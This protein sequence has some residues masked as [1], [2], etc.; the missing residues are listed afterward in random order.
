M[1]STSPDPILVDLG[2]NFMR[3]V[4]VNRDGQLAK[5]TMTPTEVTIAEGTPGERL[6]DY[7]MVQRAAAM[8]QCV[9]DVTSS[10]DLD[11]ASRKGALRVLV[12]AIEMV[13]S[14]VSDDLAAEFARVVRVPSNQVPSQTDLRIANAQ[15]TQWV[16]SLV[17]MASVV[18]QGGKY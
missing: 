10:T 15:F 18:I 1:G 8:I 13:Q 16:G 9:S 6:L 11:E 4:A 14:S 12:S 3:L 5:I 17:A 2:D 7:E